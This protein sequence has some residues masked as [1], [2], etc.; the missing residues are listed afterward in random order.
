MQIIAI[1]SQITGF[2]RRDL[3][4]GCLIALTVLLFPAVC[5]AAAVPWEKPFQMVVNS[6]SGPIARGLLILAIVSAGCAIAFSEG[7]SWIR[8]LMGVVMG[9]ALILLAV[10]FLD[11]F[12]V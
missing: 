8:Y 3:L 1:I 9:G 5:H 7:G 2:R 4:T 10:S 12:E 6:L 11:I